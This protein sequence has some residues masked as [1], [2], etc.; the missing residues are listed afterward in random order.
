MNGYGPEIPQNLVDF[1]EKN[2]K[3]PYPLNLYGHAWLKYS[4][5]RFKEWHIKP[6]E[7]IFVMGTAQINSLQADSTHAIISKGDDKQIFIVSNESQKDV[8]KKL[9]GKAI[10]FIWIGGVFSTVILGYLINFLYLVR[11]L[12]L[13]TF[14]LLIYP[15]GVLLVFCWA[16]CSFIFFGL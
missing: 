4:S 12:H 3:N 10:A 15:T 6:D 11:E 13:G 14:L 9:S 5:L 8:I 7:T 1:L 2:V 16:I